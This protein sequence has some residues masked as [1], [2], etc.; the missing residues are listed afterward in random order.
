MID[1]STNTGSQG[2]G[3]FFKTRVMAKATFDTVDHVRCV[4]LMQATHTPDREDT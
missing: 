1:T 4:F 3:G 2:T